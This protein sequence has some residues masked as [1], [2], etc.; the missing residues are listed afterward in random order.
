MDAGWWCTTCTQTG[1]PVIRKHIKSSIACAELSSP[2]SWEMHAVPASVPLLIEFSVPPCLFLS[3]FDKLIHTYPS[4]AKIVDQHNKKRR[5]SRQIRSERVGGWEQ[6][7]WQF[8]IDQKSRSGKR[9]SVSVVIRLLE[10]HLYAVYRSK[11]IGIH[12]TYTPSTPPP[13]TAAAVCLSILIYICIRYR[14]G[15][16]CICAGAQPT[17]WSFVYWPSLHGCKQLCS[18]RSPSWP[19]PWRWS[20]DSLLFNGQKER[21]RSLMTRR[22]PLGPHKWAGCIIMVNFAVLCAH[23][24]TRFSTDNLFLSTPPWIVFFWQPFLL[25]RLVGA[26]LLLTES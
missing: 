7:C 16:R 11:W 4:W 12:P 19:R 8:R 15:V 13:Y 18:F 3:Q 10:I 24:P 20:Q 2:R 26:L 25:L 22:W 17:C 6:T 5:S 14:Y 1:Q 9:R 21:D 23:E